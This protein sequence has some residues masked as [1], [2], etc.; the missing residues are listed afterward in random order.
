LDPIKFH[1]IELVDKYAKKYR[2]FVSPSDQC[3][4]PNFNR[5]AFT[6]DITNIHKDSKWSI[7]QIEQLLDKFNDANRK[8]VV[9][10]TKKVAKKCNDHQFY[11]F[12]ISKSI[13]YNDLKKLK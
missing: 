5:D 13:T 12:M 1:I 10:A 11:L 8:N 9:K 3:Q 7:G 4:R 2:A 6:S